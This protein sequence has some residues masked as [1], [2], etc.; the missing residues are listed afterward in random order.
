MSQQTG[1]HVAPCRLWDCTNTACFVSWS[2]VT[3]GISN[4]GFVCFVSYSRFLCLSSM[5][6]LYVVFCF[7]L[8]GCQYQCNWL[9]GKTRLWNDLLCVKWDVKPYT[10]TWLLLACMKVLEI[11]LESGQI[12]PSNHRHLAVTANLTSD[13]AVSSKPQLIMHHAK[14]N[15]KGPKWERQGRSESWQWERSSGVALTQFLTMSPLLNQHSLTHEMS[16]IHLAGV[17]SIL[18]T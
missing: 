9:P 17:C 18:A 12:W 15:G 3:K 7:V 5:F 14:H 6:Q 2:E 10:L 8:F 1:L 16:M 4:Q 11:S 13:P